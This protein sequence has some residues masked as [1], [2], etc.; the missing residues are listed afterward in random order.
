MEIVLRPPGWLRCPMLCMA[1][2]SLPDARHGAG[3][4]CTA[5]GG[6]TV[7]PCVTL[8]SERLPLLIIESMT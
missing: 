7:T 2:A 5:A 6:L 3:M 8:A 4:R 1:A